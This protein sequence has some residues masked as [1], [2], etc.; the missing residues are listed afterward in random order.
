[1]PDT[2]AHWVRTNL[3]VAV[4]IVA[5][6]GTIVGGIIAGTLWLASVEHLEKR[7]DVIR[8]DVTVMQA[9]ML[10]N[11]KIVSDVRR[12]LEASDASTR[13]V[14]GRLDERVRSMEHVK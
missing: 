7:V 9:T 1:M 10:E 3:G 13:E 2:V 6:L 5:V 11:R 4:A 12:Q 8:G 14:I